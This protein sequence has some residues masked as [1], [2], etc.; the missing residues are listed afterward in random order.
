MGM[1]HSTYFAYGVHIPDMRGD[2][3]ELLQTARATIDAP[4]VGYLSAGNYDRDMTFL[5][6]ECEEVALGKFET[7]TPQVESAARYAEWNRQLQAAAAALGV[8]PLTGPAWIV[9]PDLS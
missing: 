6:T 2:I 1:Y 8:K 7:V 3:E 9:V 5:V 4:D